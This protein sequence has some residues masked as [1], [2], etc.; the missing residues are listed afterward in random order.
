MPEGDTVHRSARVLRRELVGRQLT[1]LYLRDRGDV[2]ELAGVTVDRVEAL[3]KHL[4]IHLGDWVLRIHLGMKGGWTRR[5]V[6]ERLPATTRAVLV[7][8]QTAYVCAGAYTAEL[9]RASAVRTHPRLSRLGPDLLADPPDIDEAVRRAML[10]AHADREVGDVVMDQRIAAGIGNVYKSEVLF[11][12]RVHPR[13]RMRDLPAAKVR[14]VYTR[15]A[16]LM[17]LNL[18]TRRRTSVPLRRRG[19]PSSTRFWVYMRNGKPCLDC[20]AAIERFMQGD[21]HRST[22]FCPVCQAEHVKA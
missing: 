1:R 15:A 3:G 20:G 16:E 19:T 2:D 9:M 22:Y 14:E 10:P 11:E 18:L 21:M 6:K 7:V 17:R 4:L 12:T 13:T 5:H 8:D